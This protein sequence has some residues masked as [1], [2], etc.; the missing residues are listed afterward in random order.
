M[1]L[2]HLSIFYAVAEE[3][4]V[5]KGAERLHIS[6]P[7]VSKQLAEF[8]RAMGTLLFDR[9]PKGVRLTE[10]GRLLHGYARRL[11][12]IEAEAERALRELRGVERGRL[13]V[14]ASTTIG[15]YVL[16]SVLAA[17]HRAYPGVEIHLEI[18]NT[19]AIQEALEKGA[20]DLGFTE[21]APPSENVE[22]I[23][24]LEDELVAIAAPEY[25]R[26][27]L[28]DGPLT[29]ERLCEEPFLV[30][31][32]GSGTRAVIE[33]ALRQRE[34]VARPAMTL[35]NTEAIKRVVVGGGGVALISRLTIR[36][37]E[38][39]NRLVVLPL[40][41][42]TLRR[43]LRRLQMRGHQASASVRAF[44]KILRLTLKADNSLET[45]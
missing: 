14:G 34:L 30:R 19:D 26:R 9:L 23:V 16:P 28:A 21:G 44:V 31:E 32:S 37:E 39:Q 20:I 8:E 7:A 12:A 1:N 25:A 27:L 11:F 33:E 18:G 3:S 5:S 40:S 36:E 13:A 4:G 24:F 45:P 35:G 15:A 10:A 29:I 6:Q 42:F 38:A 22:A 43:P 2:N 41:D 17:F